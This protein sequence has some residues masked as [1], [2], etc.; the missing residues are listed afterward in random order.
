[1]DEFEPE[2]ASD[3]ED[4][5]EGDDVPSTSG[6][7]E[8]P[9]NQACGRVSAP[10]LRLHN[11]GGISGALKLLYLLATQ[12]LPHFFKLILCSGRDSIYAP[13]WHAEIVDFCR[14]LAPLPHE[15]TARTAAVA[16]IAAEVQSTWPSA[17]VQAFGSFVTGAQA[18]QQADVPL[19]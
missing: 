18:Q 13:C 4:S 3:S 7:D 16:R 15:V 14:A 1:M 10:L 2:R 17:E 9:W 5:V 8:L 12:L 19:P 11:G 6:R